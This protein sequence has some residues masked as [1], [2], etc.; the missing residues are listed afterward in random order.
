MRV[1]SALLRYLGL[2]DPC[3]Q[4]H[5]WMLERL[6]PAMQVRRCRRCGRMMTS[7]DHPSVPRC[8]DGYHVFRDGCCLHCG[9]GE[10]G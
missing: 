8:E 9:W 4:G 6:S 2:A 3:G 7:A 10:E 5:S 1:L